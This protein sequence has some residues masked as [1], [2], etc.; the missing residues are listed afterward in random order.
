MKKSRILMIA[1]VFCGTIGMVSSCSDYESDYVRDLQNR[2]DYLTDSISGLDQAIKAEVAAL[3]QAKIDL[4]NSINA[5]TDTTQ[6][7]QMQN[8][9]DQISNVLGVNLNDPTSVSE[10]TKLMDSLQYCLTSITAFDSLYSSKYGR[11]FDEL[12]LWHDSVIAAVAKAQEALLLSQKAYA[13]AQNDSVRIDALAQ[14]DSVRIDTL[15]QNIYARAQV[16]LDSAKSYTDNHARRLDSLLAGKADTASLNTVKM[17]S[18]K[19]DSTLFALIDSISAKTAALELDIDTLKFKIDSIETVLAAI[20][21]TLSKFVTGIIVQDVENIIWGSFNTPLGVR[22]NLIIGIFGQNGAYDSRFPAVNTINYVDASQFVNFS[23]LNPSGV[24]N[25]EGGEVLR[26]AAGKLYMTVNPNTVNFDGVKVALVNSQDAMAP[27]FDSLTL[28]KSDKVLTFFSGTRGSVVNNGFYEA[29]VEI[30]PDKAAQSQPHVNT[31]ALKN[32]AVA[33]KNNWKSKRNILNLAETILS[34]VKNTQLEAYGIKSSWTDGF[35]VE[36]SVY[37]QYDI[38]A[39]TYKPLSYSFA[40]G[41]V[42]DLTAIKKKIPVLPDLQEWMAAHGFVLEPFAFD[43]ITASAMSFQM[44]IPNVNKIKVDITDNGSSASGSLNVPDNDPGRLS[45]ATIIIDSFQLKVAGK[46]TTQDTTMTIEIPA[47][48]MQ[49]VFDQVNASVGGMLDKVNSMLGQVDDVIDMAQ[50]QLIDRINSYLTRIKNLIPDELDINMFVRPTIFFNNAAGSISELSGVKTV[51]S[52]MS[53]GKTAT[54][55]LS[56][57]TAELLA[58]AYK[59]YVAVTNV[60]NADGVTELPSAKSA[61]NALADFN[62]VLDGD[63]ILVNFTPSVKGIYE[64]AYS[65]I[66]Y[67]GMIVTR[68]FYINVR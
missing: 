47:S 39:L 49:G 37:S 38:A 9:I 6:A 16:V 30:N 22:T 21:T 55:I 28:K 40:Y 24:I 26:S 64:I 35:N 53:L 15:A 5:K 36:H 66:D 44:T 4:Q 50:S 48:M 2:V 67:S 60:W 8:L 61:A 42:V 18:M 59:K 11:N 19:A 43:P 3:Q 13:L 46:V 32:A 68:K 1:A 23:A 65:A 14:N 33:L 29:E 56:S 51:G 20:E 57:H 17:Y 7:R 63:K 62:T 10:K 52:T 34:E 27:G 31:T 54:L 41:K 45:E 12:I 58:P 25:I